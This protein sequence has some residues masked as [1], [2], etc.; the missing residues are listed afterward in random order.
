MGEVFGPSREPKHHAELYIRQKQTLCSFIYT[1]FVSP[2]ALY[3]PLFPNVYVHLSTGALA[4][5][6]KAHWSYTNT[7]LENVTTL[8]STF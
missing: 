5:T 7:T 2:V 3:C 1:S 8:G 4:D 6:G